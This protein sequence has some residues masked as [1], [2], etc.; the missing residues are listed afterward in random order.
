MQEG[1]DT[2]KF[3]IKIDL[4]TSYY[5]QYR[6]HRRR[7]RSCQGLRHRMFGNERRRVHNGYPQGPSPQ[8]RRRNC[9]RMQKE[10]INQ[11]YLSYTKN[12]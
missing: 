5:L 10:H 6:I 3:W 2:N 7:Y 9:L 1:V 8:R 4:L 12:K 11:Y